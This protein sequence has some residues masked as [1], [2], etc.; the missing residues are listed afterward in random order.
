MGMAR[1]LNTM[2]NTMSMKKKSNVNKNHQRPTRVST[3]SSGR[4]N[5][6]KCDSGGRSRATDCLAINSQEL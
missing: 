2:E 4:S 1:S 3:R 5:H 6:A